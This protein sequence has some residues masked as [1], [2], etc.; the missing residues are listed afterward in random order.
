[1]N[2]FSGRLFYAAFLLLFLQGCSSREPNS[3]KAQ[4][5]SVV[6]K[7]TTKPEEKINPEPTPKPAPRPKFEKP[8]SGYYFISQRNKDEAIRA[9]ATAILKGLSKAELQIVLKLNRVDA[10]S[11]H[12]L[13]TLIIPAHIDTNWMQQSI[14][15]MQ[16][17]IL[18]E[19]PKMVLLAYYPEAFAAY[20]NGQLVRW[21]PTSMGKRSTPTPEGL[22]SC[23]WKAKE[24]ISSVDDEWKLKWNFNFWNK[25]GVGWHEYQMPGYPASHSCV[26]MLE[27]D[28]QFLYGWAQ[29]WVRKDSLLLAQGTP[30]LVFGK[31]PFGKGKPWWKLVK[32]PNALQLTEDN[33]TEELKPLMPKIISRQAQ[34]DSVL[35]ARRSTSTVDSSAR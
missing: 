23:N 22:F 32:D 26:R 17:P 4:M 5:P 15:P 31:Y 25:G 9:E 16:L 33:L 20:E 2:F 21:G 12:R 28:A 7:P 30:V 14:F 3:D 19:V 27:S 8:H 24:S 11:Y 34:R 6:E 29:Q 13:D 1:M 35:A 10:A 18:S